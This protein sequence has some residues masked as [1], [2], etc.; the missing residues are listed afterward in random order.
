M[1]EE[2]KEKKQKKNKQG[3]GDTKQPKEKDDQVKA[4]EKQPEEKIKFSYEIAGKQAEQLEEAEKAIGGF[5]KLVKL[6]LRSKFLGSTIKFFGTYIP[7]INKIPLK[8]I[9]ANI[10]SLFA[11]SVRLLTVLLASS[12][13]LASFQGIFDES[14]ILNAL[15]VPGNF[16]K[17]GMDGTEVSSR[18]LSELKKIQE[19]AQKTTPLKIDEGNSEVALSTN[20]GNSRQQ[21][22]FSQILENNFDSSIDAEE[23]VVI[24]GVSLNSIKQIIRSALGI[25]DKTVSG[26]IIQRGD[27][28]E[29]SLR[30]SELDVVYIKNL[31]IE[32]KK[33][34]DTLDTLVAITAREVLE[35]IDPLMI[36]WFEYNSKNYEKTIKFCDTLLTEKK[37]I[38]YK[39]LVLKGFAQYQLKRYNKAIDNFKR[40]IDFSLDTLL[41]TQ[42]LLSSLYAQKEYQQIET[43]AT[44]DILEKNSKNY[45]VYDFLYLA[46]LKQNKTEDA[47]EVLEEQ[48]K[49]F[50]KYAKAYYNLSFLLLNNTERAILL[51]KKAIR[52]QPEVYYY[53]TGLSYQLWRQK[54]KQEA[55]QQIYKA[56]ELNPKA[57]DYV[58]YFDFARAF[59]F[60]GKNKE[61]I[62]YYK[63]SIK[64]NPN[65]SFAHTSLSIRYF[66]LE[67]YEE[68]IFEM[69]KA[70]K[71]KP[72]HSQ[73][74]YYLSMYYGKL[75]KRQQAERS[76]Q[77]AK[78]LNP[79]QKERPFK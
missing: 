78:R 70:I 63:K 45:I 69:E 36:G 62:E 44:K 7:I 43:I 47:I 35:Q 25:S 75:G 50:P 9:E 34:Y 2:P 68:A 28:L 22:N 15:K 5:E 76:F 57:N 61:A 23:D 24:M 27:N 40:V 26:S 37:P 54:K 33:V 4:E 17:D 65:F 10:T 18:L 52:L 55:I 72:N 41:A 51:L 48:I 29:I 42:G 6:F 53:Y 67:K 74:H 21:S 19:V 3:E 56:I 59:E 12:L 46:L 58:P 11:I 14:L 1:S 13:I 60:A 30:I 49:K 73:G 66:Q 38:K 31:P 71:L 8:K 64:I 79:K 77:E 32:K 16:Q 20:A 39:L